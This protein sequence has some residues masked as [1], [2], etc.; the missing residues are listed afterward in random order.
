MANRAAVILT[1]AVLAALFLG[2]LRAA[3]PRTGLAP[4]AGA[5]VREAPRQLG[6]QNVVTAV[7]VTYRGLDTLGEVVVLFIAATGVGF[8]LRRR[9]EDDDDDGT[10][11]RRGASEILRTG[12]DLLLP[13]VV[14]YGAFV[15][16]H[17]HLTPG[18]GFQGGV[19]AASGVLLALLAGEQRFGHLTV[20]ALESLSGLG[21]VLMGVAGLLLGAGLLDSRILPL[22][23]V[24]AMV[25]AGAVPIIYA[26]IGLKVGAEL[27]GMLV[28]MGR[29]AE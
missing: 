2:L 16:I 28:T 22:G 21:Y 7:V 9:E 29:D 23:S 3:G 25:S 26:L 1:L 11:A 27:T 18:G 5:Y 10:E 13:L 20:S 17:G 15:S 12:S 19:I 4:L 24:G 14:M 6:T 8:L